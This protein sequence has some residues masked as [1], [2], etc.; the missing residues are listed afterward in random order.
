MKHPFITPMHSIKDLVFPPGMSL[1]RADGCQIE[2]HEAHCYVE[3]GEVVEIRQDGKRVGR[4]RPANA[5]DRFT[6]SQL[7]TIGRML[8]DAKRENYKNAVNWIDRSKDRFWC[9]IC[10]KNQSHPLA[11][12]CWA[13]PEPSVPI[14]YCGICKRCVKQEESLRTL[15]DEE[16]LTRLVN[17]SEQRLIARYPHVAVNLPPG[18]MDW[19][20]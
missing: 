15:N 17:L 19:T 3:K 13:S 4:L 6:R 12:S 11:F 18:Y 7:D 20:G 1:H 16:G 9:P 5:G 2:Q 14:C 8:D 10:Q